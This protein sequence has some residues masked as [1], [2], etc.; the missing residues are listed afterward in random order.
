MSKSLIAISGGNSA[1]DIILQLGM[2]ANRI[3][4]SRHKNPNE[5]P[6]DLQKLQKGF[7]PKVTLKNDVKYFTSNGAVFEDK[8]EQTFTHV[9]YATGI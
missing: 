6:A 4:S 9:I 1:K 8:S 2:T 5:T 3:T 7:G